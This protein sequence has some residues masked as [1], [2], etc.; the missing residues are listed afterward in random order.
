ME[1]Y[2][3]FL[4][5]LKRA[6]CCRTRL[7]VWVQFQ[8]IG[9]LLRMHASGARAA[10]FSLSKN[11]RDLK[12]NICSENLQIPS[13]YFKEQ[14]P[15]RKFEIWFYKTNCLAHKLD[16]FVFD[17][18]EGKKKKFSFSKFLAFKQTKEHIL[19]QVQPLKMLNKKLVCTHCRAS[20]KISWCPTPGYK[21]NFKDKFWI[22]G[23]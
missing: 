10:K 13:F 6:H 21:Q 17:L 4:L 19:F 5:F 16:K 8:R 14:S 15:N 18:F 20:A 3:A 7:F 1:W 22:W 2:R 9:E 23:S 12:I 11:H